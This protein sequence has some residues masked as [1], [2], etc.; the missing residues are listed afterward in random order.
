MKVQVRRIDAASMAEIGALHGVAPEV[1]QASAWAIEELGSAA[2]E[3][4]PRIGGDRW[5]ILGIVVLAAVTGF[6]FM[7]RLDGDVRPGAAPAASA[8]VAD[9]A[10]SPSE[11]SSSE[12]APATA[13][14][15]FLSP[16]E[17]ATIGS[18]TVDLRATASRALG[19]LHLAVLAGRIVLG[20]TDV[21]VTGPGP[22]D[23][24]IP[25]FA[26][27][28]RVQ[29]ELV[30][31]VPGLVAGGTDAIRRSLWLSAGGPLGLWPVQVA[32]SGGTSVLIVAG[33]A[34][35]AFGR[36]LVRVTT[37]AGK[38]LGSARADIRVDSTKPGSSGG[39]SLGRGTFEERIPLPGLG[40][41]GRLL[42][43]V[44]WRDVVTGTWGTDVETIAMPGAS[45]LHPS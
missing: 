14:F 5:L 15:T 42:V 9:R 12:S 3:T 30:A 39:Y 38:P 21:E 10:P 35:L 41:G 34:P 44:D 16:D 29:V 31:T 26:P 37:V 32:R 20:A 22:V 25:A 23:V 18:T 8:A 17:G 19:R 33:H 43:E 45:P 24:A 11:V 13:A 2:P 1:E 27:P 4:A 7:G 36:V 6:G 28:V 40:D